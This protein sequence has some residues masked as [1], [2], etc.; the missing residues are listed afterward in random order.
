MT[1]QQQALRYGGRRLSRRVAR[2]IPWIG[3]AIALAALG[4]RIRRKGV[5]RGTADTALD[6]LP[7][8][9]AAKGLAEVVRG[10]EFFPDREGRR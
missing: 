3:T 6:A 9:G 4:S 10:R 8:V 7:F 5:V 2:A 1:I